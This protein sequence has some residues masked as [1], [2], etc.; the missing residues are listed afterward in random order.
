MQ[1]YADLHRS[2]HEEITEEEIYGYLDVVIKL[3]NTIQLVKRVVA[4]VGGGVTPPTPAPFYSYFLFKF[5]R[6]TST[7]LSFSIIYFMDQS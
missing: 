2:K 3:L 5:L 4:R 6:T 1:K 7:L